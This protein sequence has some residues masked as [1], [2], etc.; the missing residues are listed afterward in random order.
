MVSMSNMH[1]PHKILRGRGH[2]TSGVC[3][4]GG[5]PEMHSSLGTEIPASQSCHSNFKFL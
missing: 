2:R 3:S 5:L 1:Q 4:L